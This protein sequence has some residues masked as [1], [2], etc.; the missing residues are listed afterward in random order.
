VA[1][2]IPLAK[3]DLSGNERKYLNE[4]IDEGWLTH[5]GSFESK[6]ERQFSAY[7]GVPALAT[8][9]G[10]GALHLALLCIGCGPGDEVIVPDLT[11]GATASVVARCGATPI[12]VDIGDDWGINWEHV[13][14]RV[15]KRTRAVIPVHLYGEQCHIPERFPVPI[16]EDSC[17]GT[18]IKPTAKFSCFSF[19]GNKPISTGEGGM[20]VGEDLSLVKKYRD[21]GF[22]SNYDM[23][24]AGL[25]YRMTN[26]QAAVGCAQ[27]ERID[28]LVNTRM[29]NAQH[30]ASR[31]AGR[32]KWLF[33]AEV[34]NPVLLAG[35]LRAEGIDTRPVF[36]PLHLTQAFRK[37]GK[38][39]KSTEVWEHGICL[40]TGPHVNRDDIDRIC[41][42][43]KRH[44][45]S[46]LRA[47]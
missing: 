8:S 44:D 7:T 21:G 45:H 37:P 30:Y 17:E 11:F 40:P 19:Y 5:G 14:G 36:R 28:E 46:N 2:F 39:R 15:T 24:V 42:L 41:D 23:E 43:V 26:L 35:H 47:A 3:P 27:M 6:F 29:E 16:I 32:G 22:D 31:L 38:F 20:V 1:T 13:L 18:W 10:T 4:A 9:S 34:A 12:L 33:V 25:N